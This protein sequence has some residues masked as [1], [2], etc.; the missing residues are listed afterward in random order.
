MQELVLEKE[1][2][3]SSAYHDI[4]QPLAVIGLYIRSAIKKSRDHGPDIESDLLLIES[5]AADMVNLFKGIH[6]Y[7]ELG[8]YKIQLQTVELAEIISEIMQQYDAIAKDKNIH[9]KISKRSGFS[10]HIITDRPLFKRLLSNL[11]SNAI[12]YTFHGGVVIGWVRLTNAIRIDVW[13]TGIGIAKEH[14]EKIFSE[15]YQINNPGRDRSRGIGLG[16]SIVHKIEAILPRHQL[17]FAS[18]EGRGSR[19]SLYAPV[20]TGRR[21]DVVPMNDDGG[22]ASDLDGKYVVVCDDEPALLRGLAQLFASAGALVD[23]VGSLAETRELLESVGREPDMLVTDI[24]LQ[25]GDT[26][27]QV[28]EAI[29]SHWEVRTP[30]A[31]ITGELITPDSP[32]M[33]GFQPPF[34]IIRKSSEPERMLSQVCALLNAHSQRSGLES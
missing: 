4:Q 15:Y 20:A 31:F 25:G 12:K 9:L 2:F 28:A 24:R 3:F 29:R 23:S 27:V 17:R 11:I 21:S 30:V 19:F 5:N 1:R 8:A 7:S 16:L 33:N 26:G 22:T 10:P 34:T 6:D 14:R 32:S 18:V 13:D